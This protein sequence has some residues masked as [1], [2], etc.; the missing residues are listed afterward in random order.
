MCDV[1]NEKIIYQKNQN[2]GQSQEKICQEAKLIL[3]GLYLFLSR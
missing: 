3:D 2:I 1:L